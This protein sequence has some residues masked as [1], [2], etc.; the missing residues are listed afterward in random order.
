M[1]KKKKILGTETWILLPISWFFYYVCEVCCNQQALDDFDFWFSEGYGKVLIGRIR[2]VRKK[3]LFK[4]VE[5]PLI[6]GRDFVGE[7][8]A[9]GAKVAAKDLNVGDI[10]IGVVAPFE[11]GCHA[12]YVAV[13]ETQVQ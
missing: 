9:K 11:Q 2:Q 6:L 12:E 5:F 1:T 8:V 4:P 13:S 10:V 7:I 3:S